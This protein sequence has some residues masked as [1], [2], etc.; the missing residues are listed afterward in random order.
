MNVFGKNGQIKQVAVCEPGLQKT[1]ILDLT[2]KHKLSQLR[3]WI[4][5]RSHRQAWPSP[6]GAAL[7]VCGLRWC[8]PS[9]SPKQASAPEIC[10]YCAKQP[11]PQLSR[12]PLSAG[13]AEPKPC[14]TDKPHVSQSLQQY[15]LFFVHTWVYVLFL[16]LFLNQIE[17]GGRY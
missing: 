2:R 16:C 5:E 13:S 8:P 7:T 10:F 14:W 3:A 17:K 11:C 9:T 12:P 4:T 1:L 15:F 6:E